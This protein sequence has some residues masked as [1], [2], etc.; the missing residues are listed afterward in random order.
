MLRNRISHLNRGSLHLQLSRSLFSTRNRGTK[1]ASFSGDVSDL[2]DRIAVQH[3][4]RDGPWNKIV[5]AT[6]YCLRNRQGNIYKRIFFE[7]IKHAVL[8]LIGIVGTT[9]FIWSST[10]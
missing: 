1:E 5:S 2:Y 7:E 10:L 9:Y 6:E 8:D 4:H 3:A